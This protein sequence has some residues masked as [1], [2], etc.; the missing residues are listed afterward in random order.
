MVPLT[1]K[2]DQYA[3]ACLAYEL[4]TGHIPFSAQSFSS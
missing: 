1:E 3:L 4:I 2:S